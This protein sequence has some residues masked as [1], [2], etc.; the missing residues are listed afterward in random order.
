MTPDGFHRAWDAHG[1]H[2]PLYS[3]MTFEGERLIFGAG[4]CLASLSDV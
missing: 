1:A 3:E 4:T 2:A